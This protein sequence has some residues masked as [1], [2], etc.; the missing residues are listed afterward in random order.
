MQHN[1]GS[2]LN[3][4]TWKADYGP[5]TD[6]W[7]VSAM[8]NFIGPSHA[9]HPTHFPGLLAPASEDVVRLF[10]DYWR[11]TNSLRRLHGL[12]KTKCPSIYDTY[13]F[14]RKAWVWAEGAYA[15]SP[16]Y[17]IEEE[18]LF[19]LEETRGR[20]LH[21]QQKAHGQQLFDQVAVLAKCAQ[22]KGYVP[23]RFDRWRDY[24]P[25]LIA[26]TPNQAT[27]V[28][29]IAALSIAATLDETKPGWTTN[30]GQRA[31]LRQWIARDEIPPYMG[32]SPLFEDLIEPSVQVEDSEFDYGSDVPLVKIS[33]A[34]AAKK[35]AAIYT[36]S[37]NTIPEATGIP[38][39]PTPE[40]F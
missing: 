9:A 36:S 21:A 28:D 13:N 22:V 23:E 18:P 37:S 34:S 39:L 11:T 25:N 14:Q 7:D 8:T 5:A 26:M 1:G 16:P 29:F 2:L 38:P 15:F 6:R 30:E 19:S 32:G 20:W 4:V 31:V 3:K 12:R 27:T 33:P 24:L 40:V 10:N 35:W 17:P